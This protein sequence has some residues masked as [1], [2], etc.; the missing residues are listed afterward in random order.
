MFCG[1]CGAQMK[2]DAAFCP[3]CG[4]KTAPTINNRPIHQE[5][6]SFYNSP[7]K[8]LKKAKKVSRY[9]Q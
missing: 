4:N 2:D 9:Y 6:N 8:N 7:E 5:A 1:K 3:M